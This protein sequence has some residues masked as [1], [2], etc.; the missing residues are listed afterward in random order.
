MQS[1]GSSPPLDYSFR[2]LTSVQALGDAKPRRG[3]KRYRRS[4]SGLY[5]C[6]ALRLNNNQLPSI[7]GLHAASY[8][9]LERPEQLTWLDLSFNKLS[10]LSAELAE[11]PSLKIVYLHGNLLAELGK[12]IR[13]L[14]EL[15]QLYSLTLHGNPLEQHKKYRARILTALPQLRSLDFTNITVADK[16]HL[17]DKPKKKSLSSKI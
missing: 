3:L 14:R 5:D 13:T 1:R 8:Q 16:I 7:Q 15:P 2:N 10:S 12:A 11:F 17:T 6:H 9:V 4:S